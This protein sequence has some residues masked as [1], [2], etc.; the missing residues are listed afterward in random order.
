MESLL[1]LSVL[2]MFDCLGGPIASGACT[3]ATREASVCSGEGGGSCLACMPG[4]G[5]CRLGAGGGLLRASKVRMQPS[6]TRQM[7]RLVLASCCSLPRH[8]ATISWTGQSSGFHH[9]CPPCNSPRWGALF[10]GTVPQHRLVDIGAL[11]ATSVSKGM[12]DGGGGGGVDLAAVSPRILA[13]RLGGVAPSLRARAASHSPASLTARSC[14]SAIA[15]GRIL[16]II[17]AALLPATA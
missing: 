15:S 13:S 11:R 16:R 5:S 2:R 8:P 6:S 12:L 7:S 10:G 9:K 14:A 1:L 17:S 3:W 4:L